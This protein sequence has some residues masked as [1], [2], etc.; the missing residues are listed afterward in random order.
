MSCT[1][2]AATPALRRASGPPSSRARS[3][4]V[5]LPRCSP[6]PEPRRTLWKRLASASTNRPTS[7]ATTIAR[8][9]SVRSRPSCMTPT[10]CLLP[11]LTNSSS[12]TRS[13]RR[14]CSALRAGAAAGRPRRS[15]GSKRSLPCPISRTPTRSASPSA[16]G[17]TTSKCAPT[18]AIARPTPSRAS[19]RTGSSSS[20]T[21]STPRRSRLRSCT[22]S[23]PNRCRSRGRGTC[24]R[25]AQLR[26][27]GRT[28]RAP[29]GQTA[30]NSPACR[31]PHGR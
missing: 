9:A 12:T 10:L 7:P 22:S 3:R 19:T 27:S 21:Q 17:T 13:T 24:R 26:N 20:Q 8:S 31:T 23:A 18:M 14:R 2:P 25:F 16:S 29:S 6:G 5:P 28:C 30:D 4:T 1:E 11:S 15:T